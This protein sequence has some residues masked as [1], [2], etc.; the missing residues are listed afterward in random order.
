MQEEIGLEKS[1]L[2]LKDGGRVVLNEKV[3]AAKAGGGMGV[4]SAG[5]A[6]GQK[7]NL[8]TESVLKKRKAPKPTENDLISGINISK[9]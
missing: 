2:R 9:L 5:T 8:T 1:S 6:V 4:E 3:E 7:A